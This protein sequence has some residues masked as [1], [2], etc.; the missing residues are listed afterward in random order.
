LF[1]SDFGLVM[2]VNGVDDELLCDVVIVWW[3]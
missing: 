1:E 3:S 2:E